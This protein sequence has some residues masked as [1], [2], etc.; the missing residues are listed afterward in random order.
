MILKASWG[1]MEKLGNSFTR[2]RQVSGEGYSDVLD[3][4]GRTDWMHATNIQE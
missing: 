1:L 4:I 3:E 2:T